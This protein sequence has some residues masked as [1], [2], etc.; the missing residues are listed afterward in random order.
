MAWWTPLIGPVAEVFGKVVDV[1]DDLVPDKDLANKLKAALAQRVQ[2]IAHNEFMTVVKGQVQI[3]VAEA[4]GSSWLQ[5]NWRPLI[6]AEFGVIIFNN[7]ILAP[8]AGMIWGDSYEVML[9]IPPE[10]WSLLKLGLSGYIVGRS[11]EKIASGD[12]LKG[13]AQKVM[14][15]LGGS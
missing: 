5:R 11:V 8:Y 7:Y 13:A 1:V 12:G 2:D 10:M 14:N 3:I 6:M 15:G 4:Q 9:K